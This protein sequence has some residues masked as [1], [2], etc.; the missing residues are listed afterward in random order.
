MIEYFKG[1]HFSVKKIDEVRFLTNRLCMN[2]FNQK[3][4]YHPILGKRGKKDLQSEI[5]KQQLFE[6]KYVFDKTYI[7]KYDD[8]GRLISCKNL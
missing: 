6:Y 7:V 1:L 5:V 4:N 2:L 3:K 8:N